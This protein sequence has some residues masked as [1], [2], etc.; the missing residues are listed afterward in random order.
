MKY[1]QQLFFIISFIGLRILMLILYT[2]FKPAQP[3]PYTPYILFLYS[4]FDILILFYLYRFVKGIKQQP[5]SLIA[6]V[7]IVLAIAYHLFLELFIFV[8]T[9]D[10]TLKEIQ[11]LTLPVNIITIIAR[12]ILLIQL[13]KN[14]ATGSSKKYLAALGW[15]YV[16]IMLAAFAS[17]F[18]SMLLDYVPDAPLEFVHLLAAL[19]L[20]VMIMLYLDELKWYSNPY[21]YMESPTIDSSF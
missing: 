8:E 18:L 16:F 6:V 20:I 19:P 2:F 4:V 11:L 3:G 9:A 10:L 13:I 17:P 15:S 21:E 12:I 7:L 14:N 5:F 1:K